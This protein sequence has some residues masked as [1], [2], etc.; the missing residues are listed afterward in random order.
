[1]SAYDPRNP[2]FSP[3]RHTTAGCARS[4]TGRSPSRMTEDLRPEVESR[5]YLDDLVRQR[6]A[7]PRDDLVSAMVQADADGRYRNAGRCSA[8][9]GGGE[10]PRGRP[11]GPSV[12]YRRFLLMW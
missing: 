7:A 4:Q 10:G 3:T 5:Q 9:Q 2:T 11:P 1:M 6:R 8:L 12:P